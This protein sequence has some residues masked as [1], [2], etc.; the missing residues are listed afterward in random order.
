LFIITFGTLSFPID[1]HSA[2]YSICRCSSDLH[3]RHLPGSL[4][5]AA[6]VCRS[7]DGIWR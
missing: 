7:I 2:V 1:E 5:V 4:S 6:G 3:S